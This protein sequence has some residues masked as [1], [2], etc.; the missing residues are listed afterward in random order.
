MA[1]RFITNLFAT[2][3]A[4]AV[5]EDSEDEDSNSSDEDT[6]NRE[7]H[8]GSLEL[9]QKTLKGIAMHSV[10]E[11]ENGMGRHGATIVLGTNQW[12]TAPLTEKEERK[13]QEFFVR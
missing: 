2:T 11:G 13:T 9:V 6:Q 3:A 10:D 8:V 7:G 5:G 1:S 12:S 4:R